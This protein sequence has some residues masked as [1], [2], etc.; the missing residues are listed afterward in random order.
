MKKSVRALRKQSLTLS[1]PD[2]G[3][4]AMARTQYPVKSLLHRLIVILGLS[5]MALNTGCQRDSEQNNAPPPDTVQVEI[6][7]FK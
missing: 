7:V 2:N 6:Q 5:V 3:T 4:T 1:K